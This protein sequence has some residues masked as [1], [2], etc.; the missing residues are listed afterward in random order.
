M[1]R[2]LD[3]TVT[4]T[5]QPV[6]VYTLKRTISRKTRVPSMSSGYMKLLKDMSLLVRA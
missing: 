1:P 2:P 4:N 5:Q 6:K 3:G